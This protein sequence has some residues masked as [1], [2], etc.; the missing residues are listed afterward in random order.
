MKGFDFCRNCFIKVIERRVRKELRMSEAIKKGDNLLIIDDGTCSAKL[1]V[2]LIKKSVG[3]ITK[4]TVKKGKFNPDKKISFKGKII[5]PWNLDD[6][7]LLFMNSFFNNKLFRYLGDHGNIVK[8]LISIKQ[9]E[10]ETFAKLTG[11]KYNMKTKTD[12]L[13]GFIGKIEE[14]YPGTKFGILKTTKQML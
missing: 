14:K 11:L 7:I 12:D 1:N 9:D 2:L 3:D 10:C 6:E 13:A 4:I 8:P 5:A